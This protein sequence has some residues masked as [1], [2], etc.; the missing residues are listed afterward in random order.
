MRDR[1]EFAGKF[2]ALSVSSI[3]ANQSR[4][5]CTEIGNI[6]YLLIPKILSECEFRNNNAIFI[7]QCVQHTIPSVYDS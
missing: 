5:K 3:W 2:A 1:Q 4:V 6:F 7:P